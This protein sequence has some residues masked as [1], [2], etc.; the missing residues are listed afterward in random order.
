MEDGTPSSSSDSEMASKEKKN[1][2]STFK[3]EMKMHCYSLKIDD[4][5][6][7]KNR[8]KVPAFVIRPLKTTPNFEVDR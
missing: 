4:D 2:R 1:R 7:L 6:L 5:A 3:I 8:S